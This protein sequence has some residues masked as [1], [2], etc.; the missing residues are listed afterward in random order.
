M[1]PHGI[2]PR[3]LSRESQ[4]VHEKVI[5]SLKD[6][7]SSEARACGERLVHLR[8]LVK[9]R[10]LEEAT[11]LVFALHEHPGRAGITHADCAV[12]AVHVGEGTIVTTIATLRDR[13]AATAPAAASFISL[14]RADE[15]E[16]AAVSALM[17]HLKGDGT[18]ALRKS[19]AAR[20]PVVGFSLDGAFVLAESRLRCRPDGTDQ[21]LRCDGGADVRGAKVAHAAEALATLLVPTTKKEEVDASSRRLQT[22][23]GAPLSPDAT[24]LKAARAAAASG[25]DGGHG[26][27]SGASSTLGDETTTYAKG[28]KT[29][30]VMPVVPSDGAASLAAP[31]GFNYGLVASA[32]GGN[33]INYITQVMATSKAFYTRNS[34]GAL[35]FTPTITPVLTVNYLSSACGDVNPL[36]Y[37]SDPTQTGALDMMAFAAAAPRGYPR[38]SYDFQVISPE[39]RC[40]C[41]CF[42]VV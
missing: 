41:F 24:L 33:V 5:S 18:D 8:A 6:G 20:V 13:A 7:S 32:H 1:L 11:D 15:G 35:T 39:I 12:D 19:S 23:M 38:N 26:L 42:C 10:K 40:G 22:T 14:H 3:E 2:L 4:A 25:E 29:V 21:G 28:S 31:K 16:G 27:V 17:V 30:L 36:S 37:W 34:W 9:D